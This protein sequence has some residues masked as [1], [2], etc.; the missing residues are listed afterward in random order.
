MP[1]ASL[2]L[3]YCLLPLARPLSP[4]HPHT[5]AAS[6]QPSVGVRRMYLHASTHSLACSLEVPRCAAVLRPTSQLQSVCVRGRGRF[7]R[8]GV[9]RLTLAGELHSC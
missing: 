5:E 2:T 7:V 4:V 3:G 8:S 9:L 1:Y 6:R